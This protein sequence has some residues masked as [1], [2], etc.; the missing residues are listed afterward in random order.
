MKL[1]A[2]DIR[3]LDILMYLT[4]NPGSGDTDPYVARCLQFN[5]SASGSNPNEAVNE[6]LGLITRHCTYAIS[7]GICPLA[8]A[9]IHFLQ[10]YLLAVTLSPVDPEPLKD[11]VSE[12]SR[13]LEISD[14]ALDIEVREIFS[15][16]EQDEQFDLKALVG[17]AA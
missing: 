5:I 6:L 17:T 1:R 9:P 10:A 4:Q 15:F 3:K 13:I 7:A 11:T 8:W 16:Q 14:S 2:R 12:L